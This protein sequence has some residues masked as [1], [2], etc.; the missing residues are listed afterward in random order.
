M[1]VLPAL[2]PGRGRASR[3]TIPTCRPG[4]GMGLAQ[5]AGGQSRHRQ[6]EPLR[7]AR[8]L[9][10]AGRH[11]LRARPRAPPSCPA[12]EPGCACCAP[13]RDSG[14]YT[15]DGDAAARAG[16]RRGRPRVSA[17]G[18][19]GSGI[20]MSPRERAHRRGPRH[21]GRPAVLPPSPSTLG[22]SGTREPRKGASSCPPPEPA[23]R[24]RPRS[25]SSDSAR[26]SPAARSP[27]TPS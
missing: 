20:G 26:A 18:H 10:H 24:A 25:P 15:P 22:A 6:H 3:A 14:P 1:A 7:G 27:A 8:P 23:L 2:A 13:G 11:P 5:T 4:K 16:A 17:T 19:D 21:Q 12:R 9:A